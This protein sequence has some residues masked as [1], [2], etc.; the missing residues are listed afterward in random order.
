MVEIH[1]KCIGHASTVKPR[2]MTILT[3]NRHF[4]T[5]KS[6]FS[7]SNMKIDL[8]P[9]GISCLMYYHEWG[10]LFFYF[11]KVWITPFGY[12]NENLPFYWEK[13]P[14]MAVLGGL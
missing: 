6:C 11:S 5:V 7:I 3:Q 9:R 14:V 1:V 2:K 10:I 8:G 13:H 4:L 12:N